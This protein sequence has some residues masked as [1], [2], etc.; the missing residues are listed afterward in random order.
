M[1]R[2]KILTPVTWPV[3][4]FALVILLGACALCLPFAWQPDHQ[5]GFV[6]AL[7]ISTSAVCVTGLSTVDIG[8]TFSQAGLWVIL[9]LIQLGGLGI[10][11]YTSLVFVLWRN[12]VPFTD[13]LAV[14]QALLNKDIF[15]LRAFVRQVVA[16][17]LA[18][19]GTAAL[20]LYLHDPVLFHPFS[21]VFHAISAFCNAGFSPFP[22]NLMRFRDDLTV[23]AIIAASIVAGGLGFAVL[24]E[25]LGAL[26][27]RIGQWWQ[28]LTGTG[29]QKEHH[30]PYPR[31]EHEGHDAVADRNDMLLPPGARSIEADRAHRLDRY[32]R[33]VLKTSMALVVSGGLLVALLELPRVPT[34][35]LVSAD[36]MTEYAESG[37]SLGRELLGTTPLG[38][39]PA[40]EQ[41]GPGSGFSLLLSAFFQSVSSRTA[42]FNTVDLT[43]LSHASLL[44]LTAL[45]FIG[46]SPG[47][48]AGGIKITTFRVLSGFMSAQF[49]GNRQIVLEQR[50]VPQ[51][52]VARALTLFFFGVLTVGVSV[53]LLS[54]T[55]GEVGRSAG[56]VSAVQD[57]HADQTAL[58]P[59]L[60]EVVSALGTVGLSMNLTPQL[61]EPGK[62][63]IILNM[64]IGRVGFITL[65]TAL[66]SL[67]PVRSYQYPS[68]DIPLG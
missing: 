9:L 67:R 25:M 8:S 34:D 4:S 52:A 44:V 26:R 28:S 7:F 51:E 31:G 29:S 19:E 65:V 37:S 46:G 15:D 38:A 63:I 36:E 11:T 16:L 27:Y 40:P 43:T 14:S 66:Q 57:G 2:Q 20:L 62:V 10:T 32:S 21:A 54:I 5:V 1:N 60:F 41:G 49:R 68:V 33:M 50:A 42:G 56:V 47:S 55:E 61:S 18:F 17:V 35:S 39:R 30:A 23:N 13:R 6:D 53:V 58:L 22:D 64:F 3:L 12:R 45:M 59:L 24:R 48:C